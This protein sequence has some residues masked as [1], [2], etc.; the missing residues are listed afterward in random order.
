MI[1]DALDELR[2]LGDLCGIGLADL[3]GIGL[4]DLFGQCRARVA[5]SYRE[6]RAPRVF[7]APG[8]AIRP[9]VLRPPCFVTKA[10]PPPPTL[11]TDKRISGQW[12]RGPD[13]GYLWRGI[14]LIIPLSPCSKGHV[15]TFLWNTKQQ[16]NTDFIFTTAP[17]TVEE[18]SCR[19]CLSQLLVGHLKPTPGRQDE[20]VNHFS[21]KLQDAARGLA[22]RMRTRRAH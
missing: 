14:I 13:L 17:D 10:A 15:E 12:N 16:S 20:L 1:T 7:P 4:A 8:R 11:D 18:A 3:C 5:I 9:A 22:T 21:G 6:K 19:W 2:S